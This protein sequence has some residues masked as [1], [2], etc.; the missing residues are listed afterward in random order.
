MGMGD[1]ENGRNP[2][3][4]LRPWPVATNWRCPAPYGTCP[5]PAMIALAIAGR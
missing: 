1:Q 3:Q 5:G 4:G 2:T